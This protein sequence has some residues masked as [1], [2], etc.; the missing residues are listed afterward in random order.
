MTGASGSSRSLLMVAYH[1]PPLAGSSGIQ[2]ALRLVQH[3][4]A[5]GWTPIVLTADERAYERTGTDMLADIPAG[6]HVER[7]F[8]LD[9][10]RHLSV[11]GRYL[12]M[13]ARPDR[14]MSWKYDAVRRGLALVKVYRPA[15]LWST[16]P[17][18]T[19]HVIGAE[20]H[21]R[22]GLPWVADFRDPMAQPGYPSDPVTH[23]MF[24]D[25]EAHALSHAGLCTFTTPGAAREYSH[26][27]PEA[28][29][30]IRIVENGYDE[31]SFAAAEASLEQSPLNPGCVTLL[32]SGVVYPSERDPS[33]LLEALSMLA[34]RGEIVPG[35]LKLRFRA[36]A[37]DEMIRQLADRHAVGGFVELLPPVG[38]RDA[39]GEMLRAD[40]LLV[41]Q[42][43]NCND[44]VPAKV[45]EY[46]RSRR[47]ILTL[48]DPAG[49]TA[50]VLQKAGLQAL[51]PLDDAQRIAA[52][53]SAFLHG[54]QPGTLPTPDAVSAASRA[55]RTAA[56]VEQI[57]ALAG[58]AGR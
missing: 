50:A 57:E 11:A 19:A 25:I 15:V 4:P 32:H 26:R 22:T 52:L 17:I 42:A 53:L 37:H 16:Y 49:D 56:L 2:R 12:A 8:A 30:R 54:R 3:L 23:R 46:L 31:S 9:A 7:A 24:R 35:R 36:S 40:A 43:S 20:L 48:A 27:Y 39:L 5:H 21:R 38:Y 51:S 29:H 58:P 55:G 18:A 1:F 33:Q 47:P 41:M 14:W 45:Y 6:T 34:A 28:A 10:A 44:Q 13:T